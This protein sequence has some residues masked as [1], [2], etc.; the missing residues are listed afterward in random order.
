MA[1]SRK[2]SPLSGNPTRIR[3]KEAASSHSIQ[4]FADCILPPNTFETL[5]EFSMTYAPKIGFQ[6]LFNVFFF[7]DNKSLQV[8]A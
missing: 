3:T 1:S 6:L 7:F 2:V 8:F 4:H 5:Y